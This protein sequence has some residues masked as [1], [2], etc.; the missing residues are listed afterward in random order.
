MMEKINFIGSRLADERKRLG[1]TQ[2]DFAAIGGVVRHTVA[3][4]EKD[5]KFPNADFLAKVS[6]LGV[7]TQYVVTGKR[8]GDADLP[9]REKALID[10]YRNA[11][12]DGKKAL[13][14]TAL[15]LAEHAACY[16]IHKKAQ[17]E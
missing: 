1:Y 8:F 2:I 4:W 5:K 14:R 11:D 7:D 15:A 13:E 3:L 17:G 16:E 10:N 9:P 12:D 6:E